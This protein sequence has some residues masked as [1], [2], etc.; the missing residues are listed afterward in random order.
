MI[1]MRMTSLKRS[2][3]LL[4]ALLAGGCTADGIPNLRAL[5]EVRVSVRPVDPSGRS[6]NQVA[7]AEA[8]LPRSGFVLA[9]TAMEAANRACPEGGPDPVAGVPAVDVDRR[10][11]SVEYGF[12]CLPKRQLPNDALVPA[13]II[14]DDRWPEAPAA[15]KQWTAYMSYDYPRM[16]P[17][18]AFDTLAG[19]GMGRAHAECRGAPFVVE[20]VESRTQAPLPRTGDGRSQRLQSIRLLYRCLGDAPRS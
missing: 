7:R 11:Q 10:Y 20:R 3:L 8:S 17:A 5:G 16:R 15:W 1:A 13:A 9:S 2:P 19:A 14:A 18:G 6:P 12:R 4:A